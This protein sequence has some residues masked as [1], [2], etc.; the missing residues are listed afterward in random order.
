MIKE[1]SFKSYIRG[2]F[3]TEFFEAIKEYAK[4]EGATSLGFH[5]QKN[6][7]ISDFTLQDIELKRFYLENRPNTQIAF[8]AV[9]NAKFRIKYQEQFSFEER[10]IRVSCTADL[11]KGLKDFQIRNIG[12]YNH[13]EYKIKSTYPLS[14]A[15]T[16][17]IKK[18]EMDDVAET[19]L[20]EYYPE[21][22]N[23]EVAIVPSILAR[24]LGLKIRVRHLS[25]DCSVF[26]ATV[27]RETEIEFYDETS[28]SIIK[29]RIPAQTILVDPNNFYLRNIGSVNNT[30]IHECVHWVFHRKA[31]ELERLFGSEAT[32]IKSWVDPIEKKQQK[33]TLLD[34]LEWQANALAP[35]ILIPLHPFVK[36]VESWIKSYPQSQNQGANGTSVEMMEEVVEKTQAFYGVSR[37]AAKIRLVEAGYDEVVGIYDFVSGHYVPNY[38][39]KRGTLRKNQTFSIS[40]EDA[41][42]QSISNSQLK[43]SL[44]SGH[45]VF[46]ESHFCLNL[47]KYI[48]F[49]E[50]G[51]PHL[52]PYARNHVDECCLIF[53]YVTDTQETPEREMHPL[54]DF[55]LYRDANSG[56]VYEAHFSNQNNIKQVELIK[57]RTQEIYN[58]SQQL[59]NSFSGAVAYLIEYSELTIETISE[60]S[61][62]SEKTIQRMKSD[63]QNYDPSL[64]TIVQFCIGLKLPPELSALLFERSSKRLTNNQKHL[65]YQFL[66]NS[67]YISSLFDCNEILEAQGFKRLGKEN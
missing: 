58:L 38:G 26:G 21:A 53:D 35:R 66:L 33:R 7:E 37:T 34:W 64:E 42:F 39:F 20:S 48:V 62:L 43:A 41:V 25:K 4:Q 57:E 10:W 54:F 1:N 55:A 65:T 45:Y 32:Q 3:Y 59:P 63:Y 19:F 31:F 61:L 2:H 47:E 23:E 60:R 14:G 17:M 40:L 9:W 12:L 67:C 28:D 11:V 15:L 46:V 8:D 27:F 13:K 56:I 24:R 30:I 29:E 22:L 5:I 51:R 44:K 49:D 6:Q 18:E 50:R 36:K 52:T 16:L